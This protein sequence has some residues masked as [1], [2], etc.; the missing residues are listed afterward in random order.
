MKRTHKKISLLIAKGLFAFAFSFVLAAP[1]G[2]YAAS[3]PSVTGFAGSDLTIE[4]R[5]TEGE[6]GNVN[7]PDMI[8]RYGLTYRLSNKQPAVLETTLPATR[9]YT[10]V[11]DGFITEEQA[12][13][14]LLE[15]PG[16][17]LTPATKDGTEAV[18]KTQTIKGLE[19]ND[20]D[21][22][23]YTITEN[24]TEFRRAAV[25]YEIEKGED[26]APAYDE[27]GLPRSYTAEVVYRGLA[28]VKIPG[29]YS[30]SQTYETQEALDGVAQY[31]IVTTYSP[32]GTPAAAAPVASGGTG[33]TD[34]S[35]GAGDGTDAAAEE[36]GPIAIGSLAGTTEADA[37]PA[38]A[39]TTAIADEEAPQTAGGF[40]ER[41]KTILFLVLK[42]VIIA[43]GAFAAFIVA[44]IVRNKIRRA[45]RL[46]A[47]AAYQ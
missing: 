27:F 7:I 39:K 35:G 4:Y 46:R 29:Y 32:A 19:T 14:L 41:T 40:A 37:A 18:D 31:V 26:G 5:Y 36:T 17:V 6:E 12:A 23:P 44:L 8:E 30:A 25:R 33:G 24:Q 42:I 10:W 45:R 21:L 11:I 1:L 47:R 43:I 16:L 28:G 15:F 22:I 34:G 13:S 2:I 3:A 9:T 38:A 20:V